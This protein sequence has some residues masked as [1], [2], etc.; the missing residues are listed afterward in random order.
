MIGEKIY[1]VKIMGKPNEMMVKLIPLNKYEE[2]IF[3]K[4]FYEVAILHKNVTEENNKFGFTYQDT[5]VI[6]S[7]IDKDSNDKCLA[8]LADIKS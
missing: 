7:G 4:G 5:F 6:E 3:K 8:I 1:I 2:D